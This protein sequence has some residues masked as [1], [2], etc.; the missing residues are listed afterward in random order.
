MRTLQSDEPE[1]LSCGGPLAS[2]QL[3]DDLVLIPISFEPLAGVQLGHRDRLGVVHLESNPH[4]GLPGLW[5][6][7]IPGV[8]MIAAQQGRIDRLRRMIANG[9][10]A[11]YVELRNCPLDG[12]GRLLVRTFAGQ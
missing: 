7:G 3:G 9:R 12:R 6:D 1:L 2:P 10:I 5:R 4:P 11:D 8:R